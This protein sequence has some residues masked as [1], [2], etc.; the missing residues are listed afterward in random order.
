[1][2]F[3]FSTPFHSGFSVPS[4]FFKQRPFIAWAA[5]TF[6]FSENMLEIDN[7]Q[8][9][10]QVKLCP[11]DEKEPA[12]WFCLIEG[13]NSSRR[14]SNRK[15]SSLQCFGQPAHASL[16]GHFR[17]STVSADETEW[18]LNHDYI[19][20]VRAIA[21][22]FLCEYLYVSRRTIQNFNVLDKKKIDLAEDLRRCIKPAKYLF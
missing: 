16:L 3:S 9:T 10:T 1:M 2:P 15:N 11:Y 13:R 5:P 6:D 21:L 14:V 8:T 7:G 19:L 20:R 22:Q 12:I 18:S 4:F 17:H